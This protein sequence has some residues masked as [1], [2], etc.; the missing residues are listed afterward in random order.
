M[1][2]QHIRPYARPTFEKLKVFQCI[3]LIS[4]AIGFGLKPD[5][6]E[7]VYSVELKNTLEKFEYIVKI[8]NMTI[9]NLLKYV[10]K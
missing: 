2:W 10:S 9:T 7:F 4:H 3:L 8:W 6:G 5:K 1:T